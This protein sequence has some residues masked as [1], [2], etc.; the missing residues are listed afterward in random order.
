MLCGSP[1]SRP[2]RTSAN[3]SV[4]VSR[5]DDGALRGPLTAIPPPL[6]ACV[7]RAPRESLLRPLHEV[8]RRWTKGREVNPRR[9]AARA[10]RI[11]GDGPVTGRWLRDGAAVT[12]G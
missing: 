10:R 5:H 11:G 8:K 7:R 12:A 6:S 1:T 4:S 9:L 3:S 2:Y